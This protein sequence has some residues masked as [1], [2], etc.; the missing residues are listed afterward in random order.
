M[1]EANEASNPTPTNN[2]FR[3]NPDNVEEFKVTTSNPTP[4]E[5]KNSGLNVS[6]ATRSGTNQFHGSLVE[7]FRNN[8]LNSNEFYAN[9]Q[10]QARAN[11]K[12]N[13]YGWKWAARIQKNKT[14]F[15]SAWQGQKVSLS[16]AIDKAFAAVRGSIPRRCCPESIVTGSPI[17]RIPNRSTA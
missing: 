9:A 7:Y 2:V 12:G 11:L 15:Y 5:G 14:F 3:V 13:Q 16:Q 4:E 10:G 17:R 8:D 1:I 6:I